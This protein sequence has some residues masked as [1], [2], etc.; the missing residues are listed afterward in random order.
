ML[1][2]YLKNANYGALGTGK[3]RADFELI[4]QGALQMDNGSTLIAAKT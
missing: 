3:T 2:P 1:T 4:L